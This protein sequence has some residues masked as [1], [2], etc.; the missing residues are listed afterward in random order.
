MHTINDIEMSTLDTL[1]D[2]ILFI[3]FK[4]SCSFTITYSEEYEDTSSWND[5][6]MQMRIKSHCNRSV[7]AFTPCFKEKFTLIVLAPFAN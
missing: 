4:I 1:L 6:V 5:A 7:D 2:D 3:I